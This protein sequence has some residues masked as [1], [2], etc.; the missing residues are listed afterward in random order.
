LSVVDT[1]KKQLEEI[2]TAEH[3]LKSDAGRI[4]SLQRKLAE[5]DRKLAD[6]SAN[7]SKTKDASGND[8]PA[9]TLKSDAMEAFK[10]SDPELAKAIEDSI[11]AAYGAIK[12]ETADR[13]REITTA[14][15]ESAK[16]DFY[17]VEWSKLVSQVPNAGAVFQTPEWKTWRE[18]QTPGVRALADSDYSD[19]V[20]LALKMFSGMSVGPSRVEAPSK[21]TEAREHRLRTVTPASGSKGPS[22][23]V[24][25]TEESLFT[26]IYT[27]MINQNKRR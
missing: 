17:E 2:K 15:T 6:I 7:P 21:I 20:V 16:E 18:Q 1:L 22:P 23:K 8:A 10:V 24:R 25:H 11:A 3:K 26:K 12:A 27:D 4:P 14:F 13:T 9:F 19:D 5:L